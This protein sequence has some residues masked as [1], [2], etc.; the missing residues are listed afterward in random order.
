MVGKLAAIPGGLD[1][2]Q[3]Y[4]HI[5]TC[6]QECEKLQTEDAM[7]TLQYNMP[8]DFVRRVSQ[9][10]LP[11]GIWREVYSCM[12]FIAFHGNEPIGVADVGDPLR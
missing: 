5:D 7:N 6:I 12:Q 1:I 4:Q 9:R 2:E 11:A 3:T 8:M 10:K